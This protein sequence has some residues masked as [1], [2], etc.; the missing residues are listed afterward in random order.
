M[1]FRQISTHGFHP[2]TQWCDI[3]F[4]LGSKIGDFRAHFLNL[5]VQ[6][7]IQP[8][9]IGFGFSKIRF[10][11]GKIRSQFGFD[12]AKIRLRGN[13]SGYRLPDNVENTTSP[14]VVE[15]SFLRFFFGIVSVQTL[16][17]KCFR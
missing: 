10:G 12:F 13:L 6:L 14:L 3:R 9:D 7:G 5:D 1:L 11:F 4:R 2:G 15:I 17:I 16:P 8:D